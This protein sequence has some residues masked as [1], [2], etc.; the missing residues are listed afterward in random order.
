MSVVSPGLP[1]MNAPEGTAAAGD[2]TVIVPLAV[3]TVVA[4]PPTTVTAS[5]S[6]FTLLTTCADAIFGA[7]TPLSASCAVPTAPVAIP[8]FGYVPAR[9]PPAGPVG[10]P[11]APPVE[12]MVNVWPEGVI[13]TFD[14]AA[15]LRSPV[16]SFRLMT[17][18]A[19]A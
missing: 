14:P 15:R 16:R 2:D 7:V 17:L 19:G 4:P 3:E 9:L 11:P 18:G 5:L 12:A 1:S 8:G 10:A 13:V 6:P